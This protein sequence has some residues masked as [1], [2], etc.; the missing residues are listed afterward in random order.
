MTERA[1]IYWQCRR[2]M[3]ELDLLLQS[4]FDNH[5]DNLTRE[6]QQVFQLLLKTPDQELVEYL[7]ARKLHPDQKIADVIEQIRSAATD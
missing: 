3:R 1:R 2:G 4:F 5:Y 6:N 7:M